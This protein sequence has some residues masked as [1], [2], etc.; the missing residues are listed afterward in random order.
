[1]FQPL[2]EFIKAT[3]SDKTVVKQKLSN[4]TIK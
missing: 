4:E 3:A 2:Y 1:M